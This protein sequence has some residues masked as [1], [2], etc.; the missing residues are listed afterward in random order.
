MLNVYIFKEKKL[1]T[2]KLCIY[3]NFFFSLGSCFH[4]YTEIPR[5]RGNYLGVTLFQVSLKGVT[6]SFKNLLL[7]LGLRSPQNLSKQNS[8]QIA[9]SN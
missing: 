4:K 2:L 6:K 5:D 9:V 1:I 7:I 8:L 3:V